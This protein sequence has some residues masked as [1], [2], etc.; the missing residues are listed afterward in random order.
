MDLLEGI[1]ATIV[2]FGDAVIKWW[3]AQAEAVS[4][5]LSF[6]VQVLRLDLAIDLQ[7]LA[8]INAIVV[9]MMVVIFSRPESVRT[10]VLSLKATGRA[11]ADPADAPRIAYN[12]GVLTAGWFC[13]ASTLIMTVY[14]PAGTCG[15]SCQPDSEQWM[16]AVASALTMFGAFAGSLVFVFRF[17]LLRILD[18]PPRTSGGG[19]DFIPSA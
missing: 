18:A 11:T 4:A 6:A 13:L 16:L 8:T 17:F 7:A 9:A 1:W 14:R 5:N 2:Q 12:D 19:S 3:L 10:G 15:A